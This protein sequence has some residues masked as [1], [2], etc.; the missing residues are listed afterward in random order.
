MS[1]VKAKWSEIGRIEGDEF[2]IPRARMGEF[3]KDMAPISHAPRPGSKAF[4][5]TWDDGE[6]ARRVVVE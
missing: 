1:D 6:R 4:L 5:A 3:V 2:V